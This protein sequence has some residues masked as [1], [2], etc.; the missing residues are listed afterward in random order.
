MGRDDSDTLA[1]L[2]AH[3]RELIDP[4]I[5]EY[6]GRIVK[7]TGDGLL[8][9]FP[10]VVDA[11][12]CAV[13]I[14][15]GMAERNAPVP[16]DQRIDFRI[17][18][19]VGDI[20]IDGGDI[21]GDGV[22]VAARLQALA[23][24]GGICASKVVRDQVLDKLSFTFADLGPH[25]V[26]NIARPVE[27]Y[28]VELESGGP[29]I[30]ARLRGW[31][32]LKKFGS[33][34]LLAMGALALVMASV[35]TWFWLKP[36]SSESTIT[37]PLLSVAVLP[38][39]APPGSP[40]E[41][42][43]ADA[44]TRDLTAG[45]AHTI[46][47]GSPTVLQGAATYEGKPVDARAVGRELN[48][49]YLAEGEIRRTGDRL[50]VAAQLVDTGR[51]TQVWNGRLEVPEAGLVADPDALVVRLT[52]QIRTALY[53]A[54]TRR[55]DHQPVRRDSPAEL[56]FRARA[57]WS[58]ETTLANALEAQKLY[59]E[60]LRLDPN[61]APAMYGRAEM[62]V[63]QLDSGPNPD[64][65]RMAHEA[66]DLTRRALAIA[67]DDAFAW[68]V[69]AEAL[70]LQ[71]RWDAALD[72]NATAMRLDPARAS[73]LGNRALYMNWM[74]RPA[75]ALPLTA[76]AIEINAADRSFELRVAC[77]AYL[78][79]GRYDDAIA[80]C[81]KSAAEDEYWTVHVYLVAAYAQ[82]GETAK[83]ATAKVELLKRQ[84]KLTIKWYKDLLLQVSD[85]TSFH[86]EDETHL[87]AGLRKAGIP[88]E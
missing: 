64:H 16:P 53:A 8:L 10:S 76:K 48:V 75:E 71:Y 3:R 74:G 35:G 45:L 80:A 73:N 11:V 4:K 50:F 1:R 46:H 83:A 31:P 61:F 34:R 38:F 28:R 59:D 68:R 69:R 47:L 25:Q 7:T 55:I 85:N 88:E 56:A 24:P 60:A 12:R 26:K 20:I 41:Q 49:R 63:E 79:L 62:I 27:A 14:Q 51:S 43:F 87:F 36:T 66:D 2:K 19:N 82:K 84:P 70:R 5:A 65:E 39:T 17:G 18:I 6:D 86:E 77:R 44:L 29:K 15:R 32:S 52:A 40:A 22:N 57:I 72:A 30:V 21:F 54:E 23:E 81:E 42:Q 37:A 13:D 9:E 58:K 33:R 67:G 78:Q